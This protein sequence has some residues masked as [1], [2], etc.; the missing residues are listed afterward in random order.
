M[1]FFSAIF[2][3]QDSDEEN[4]DE[5]ETVEKKNG[6]TPKPTN[7]QSATP[8][9]PPINI[10]SAP[11]ISQRSH[12]SDNSDSSDSSIEEIEAPDKSTFMYGPAI[13][14][15]LSSRPKTDRDTSSNVFRWINSLI[16]SFLF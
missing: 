7:V 15:K 4:A 9:A 5:A 1:D 14:N 10:P 12:I 2:D 8:I 3:N 11:L 6:E 16:I 13:P